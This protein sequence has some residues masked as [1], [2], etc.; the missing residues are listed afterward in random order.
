[1]P[2][3]LSFD[4]RTRTDTL[5]VVAAH[6]ARSPYPLTSDCV[7][8]TATPVF[9]LHGPAEDTNLAGERCGVSC[10]GATGKMFLGRSRT[11]VPLCSI[12][13][14]TRRRTPNR[15]ERTSN[16]LLL[17]RRDGW[18]KCGRPC[19]LL[20]KLASLVL[21]MRS[22]CH[23]LDHKGMRKEIFSGDNG[24]KYYYEHCNRCSST[25][26]RASSLCGKNI[27]TISSFVRAERALKI[28]DDHR[29]FPLPLR[30]LSLLLADENFWLPKALA[31]GS[32]MFGRRTN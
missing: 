16:H 32:Y 20:G 31:T 28:I 27:S 10:V 29:L 14:H 4:D 7:R 2:P 13:S 18:W 22:A 23:N 19:R 26:C 17:L 21:W 9:G 11:P 25:T 30:P 5:P 12:R 24:Q 6:F 3:T 1:M 8:V 15:P